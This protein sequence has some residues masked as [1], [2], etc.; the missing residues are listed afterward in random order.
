MPNRYIG[1]KETEAKFDQD[2]DVISR[3]LLDR[4]KS[5]IQYQFKLLLKRLR[6]LIK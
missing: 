4:D 1:K 3:A 6:G 2:T 5:G